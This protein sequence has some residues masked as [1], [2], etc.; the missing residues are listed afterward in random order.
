MILD[1]GDRARVFIVTQHGHDL[2][3]SSQLSFVQ[4]EGTRGAIRMGM[5]LNLDY[6][7]GRPDT[8]AYVERGDQPMEWQDLPVTGNWF[9][10]AF[11]GSMGSLQA[12]VE[13]SVNDLP[14]NVESAFETMAMV[15]AAY[16]SSERGGEPLAI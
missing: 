12:Y 3:P 10:D 5:G 7:K 11:V 15:E 6:P 8:L 1:Y 2:T 4:W 16:R 14:T 9:P 13:G